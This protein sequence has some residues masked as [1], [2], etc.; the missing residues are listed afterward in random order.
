MHHPTAFFQS[1]K[2]SGWHEMMF[3]KTGAATTLQFWLAG[4]QGRMMNFC[5]NRA[6]KTQRRA[7]VVHPWMQRNCIAAWVKPP[8]DWSH[9]VSSRN[10]LANREWSMMP[11]L[12]CSQSV[13]ATPTSWPSAQHSGQ[14]STCNMPY[15]YG[16]SPGWESEEWESGGEDWP[17]AYR[18]CPMSREEALCCIVTFFHH[19]WQQ[20][21]FMI[22]T[23]LLF[24]LP[25]AVT[26]FNRYSRFVE[27]LS[28]RFAFCLTSLYFDD[29]HVTDR[30]SC[31][32]SGQQAMQKLNALLGTP[33]SSEKCQ[34]MQ[35]T[36]TFLGLDHDFSQVH[37]TGVIQ[38]WARE[39]IEEKLLH[40][41][42]TAEDS[43]KLQ[44]GVAAKIYGIANFFELGVW[45]RIGCG[46]LAPIKR[47]QQERSSE[48]TE[49]LRQSFTLLRT[50][51][52][53]K[54]SRQIEIWPHAGLRFL[55]A[56]DAALES[57]CQGTGGFLIVW[58][59]DSRQQR[60]AFISLI[61]PLVYDLWGPGD[62]KIAQ[63]EL[64][65]VL[66]AL[67]SRPAS[68]RGRR[69]LWFIDNTAALMALI[70]GRSDNADLEHMSRLIHLTLFALKAWF[71]WEWIPSKANWSDEISREGL[72]ATW[73]K[74]H[75]FTTHLA[76]FPFEIW[77][78]PLPVFL[79][80]VE[81][82]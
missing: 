32:G 40:L 54:P 20:P 58:H 14:H 71:F 51:I 67:F 46:G 7:F 23:G 55:A 75:G 81:F 50:V 30:K 57:P 35:P 17:D 49:E 41:M 61:P 25:L 33:F 52:T 8:S 70:R 2:L 34:K 72:Q 22:Y 1:K 29:A 65:Q 66:Y 39:R 12:G 64:L 45:G 42:Q 77:S 15:A 5:C 11:M 24:G 19:E 79:R 6:S 38:F 4:S 69:G 63:L 82:L 80:V 48:L 36:G 68:F 37:S 60:E 26:S 44:P 27:A 9:V 18:F 74:R 43:S 10:P 3:F 73:H 53:T 47:R 78:L 56:S 16:R 76:F 28:R 21:A 13:P 62:K 59:D 31:K